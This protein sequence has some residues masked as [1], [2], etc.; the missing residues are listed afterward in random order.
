[1]KYLKTYEQSRHNFVDVVLDQLTFVLDDV[2]HE[3]IGDMIKLVNPNDENIE[4]IN[5]FMNQLDRKFSFIST[6]N[7]N[8][9]Y[10]LEVA[11]HWDLFINSI[12]SKVKPKVDE[13][14]Y[15]NKTFYFI[16]D[17]LF[18]HQDTETKTFW[19]SREN[20]WSVFQ[21]DGLKYSEIS[22]YLNYNFEKHFNCSGYTT[23]LLGWSQSKKNTD[24]FYEKHFKSK[25]S[26]LSKMADKVSDF[27]LKFKN[28][29]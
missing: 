16:G 21:S 12:L 5:H 4:D 11:D 24:E 1:M 7:G 10:I 15:P 28:T 13:V 23:E 20:L 2:K 9:W 8:D 19:C 22:V 14:E 27:G 26:L 18:F 25:K 17:K 29:K 6:K 3:I